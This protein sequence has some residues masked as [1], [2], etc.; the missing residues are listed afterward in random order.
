M[1]LLHIYARVLTL[2]GPEARLGW[3]LALGN[4]ALAG[5][6]FAEP[7]LFGRIIDALAGA[8]RGGGPAPPST[9]AGL[10]AGWVAF[11]LFAIAAGVSVALHA[12]RLA[13][14]RRHAVLTMY[15]EHV[16][17]LPLAFHGGSHS[18]RLMKVMLSGTDALWSLWLDF[19]RD[20]FAATMMI[21]VILPLS[22]LLN[23]RL[24]ITLMA[25]A[26]TFGLLTALVV[27]KTDTLQRSVEQHYSNL[28]ERASDTLGNIALVQGYARV[29]AEVSGL[30]NVIDSLLAAQMPVLSWWAVLAV[31]T[32]ASTTLTLLAIFLCGIWLHYRGDASIGDIVMFMN[33]S[34]LLI[35]Q[36]E[37]FVR[38][39]NKVFMDAPRLRE[40]FDVLDTE[41]AVRD[42]RDAVDPGRLRG[43]VEFSDVSFSYDG[44]RA[45]VA[46]LS[47]TALPGETV[48]LVGAT[49]AGKSTA[50]A[51]LHRA[52][53]PQSG[54]V[55]ID[56]MDIRG[57]KLSGL[58]HN[59]G[60]VFQEALLFNRSIAEN[61][62]AG[63]A[64]ATEAEMR[65]AC[66]R[67]Q[68]IEFI[69][70]NPEGFAAVAGERGR[71]LSGGERQRLSIARALLKD[72]PVLILD[73][74]TSA[75]DAGTEAKVQAALDEVMKHRTTFVIAHR[76]STVRNATRILVFDHGRIIESGSF[77]ELVAKNGRF[78]EL[79]R[80]QFM[81]AAAPPAPAPAS[82]DVEAPEELAAGKASG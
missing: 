40:F 34:G 54:T 7:V 50:L 62:Q 60:V 59:I 27:A 23:W 69:E 42:R 12:D 58:R 81:V 8:A 16:L 39:V 32:R 5:A 25:V 76:L 71:A 44:K 24:G 66:A 56:G 26:A 64:D 10:V 67:A 80:A 29:E 82:R 68:A 1:D 14:R 74:A 65:D 31:I 28:A 17:Q 51:L 57:L 19:F 22:L 48:A 43:M 6:Q 2:L 13:H 41:P 4:L 79:A 77:D 38:F 52:F 11:G 47:F 49:G 9:I 36:L 53:D 21:T 55:K 72:P 37:R 15:F 73:E 18:G 30:R 61:L 75:L 63:K 35:M 70:R 46:D 78:A 3:L 45:A 20:S 33:F